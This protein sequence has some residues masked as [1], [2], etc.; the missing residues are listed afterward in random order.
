MSMDLR[1]RIS[2]FNTAMFLIMLKYEED[3]MDLENI[4][5]LFNL[6]SMENV[7]IKANQIISHKKEVFNGKYKM[8]QG[9]IDLISAYFYVENKVLN[10]NK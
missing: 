2:L 1:F 8:N 7:S 10:K 3:N 4:K 5:I 9:F 6:H